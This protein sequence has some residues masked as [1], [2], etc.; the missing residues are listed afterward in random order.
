MFGI[1]RGLLFIILIF[2][3]TGGYKYFSPIYEPRGS[4]SASAVQVPEDRRVHI[5]YGNNTGG[6]HL[7]G[8]GKP[9]K[10]EFPKEWDAGE[11]IQHVKDVAANDNI[12]WKQQ[13]NGYFTGEEN[14]DG[15]KMRVVVSKDRKEVITAYPLNTGRNPC[16]ARKSANDNYN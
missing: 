2:L 1:R 5:L 10:S 8:T 13:K 4:S 3:F 6:G 16:P 9:C 11:V 14:I 7:Y 15:V 12:H